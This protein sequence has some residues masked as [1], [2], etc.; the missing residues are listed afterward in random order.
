ML[1][2]STR[3]GVPSSLA[4]RNMGREAADWAAK[5]PCPGSTQHSFE[6][7]HEE[8]GMGCCHANSKRWCTTLGLDGSEI[9][10]LLGMENLHQA[11]VQLIIHRRWLSQFSNPARRHTDR[12]GI[13][14]EWRYSAL[15]PSAA[16]ALGGRRRSRVN[17]YALISSIGLGRTVA[18]A[19]STDLPAIYDLPGTTGFVLNLGISFSWERDSRLR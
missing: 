11:K 17:Q 15:R 10:D 18:G 6:R 14:S 13:L 5:E 1:P 16:Y 19:L 3:I 2:A 12:G 7:I 8:L 9:Y 4:A